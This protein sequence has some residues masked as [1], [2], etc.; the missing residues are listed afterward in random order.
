MVCGVCYECCGSCSG[1][2][3]ILEAVGGGLCIPKVP[4]MPEV[5][6]CVLLCMLEVLEMP[7]VMHCVLLYVLDAVEGS[8]CW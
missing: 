1:C 8:L 2:Y 7:Q 6:F 3:C 4:E 5:M